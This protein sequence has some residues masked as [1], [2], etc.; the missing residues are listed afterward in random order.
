MTNDGDTSKGTRRSVRTRVVPEDIL[1]LRCVGRPQISPDG[2]RVVF[3]RRHVGEKNEYVSD[4]WIVDADGRS[5]PKLFTGG[6][7]DTQPRFSPD[8][9]SV[10]FVRAKSKEQ[11]QIWEIQAAGGEARQLSSFPEGSIR[12]F[13]W[14]Q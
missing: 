11:P 13:A 10:A 2:A 12:D 14:A 7:R 3:S 5:Q 6:G 4:L 9:R 1:E 8:G